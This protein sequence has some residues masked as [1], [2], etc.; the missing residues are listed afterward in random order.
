MAVGPLQIST[1]AIVVAMVVTLVAAVVGHS[2]V[3]LWQSTRTY[4]DA[5][6]AIAAN[7]TIDH[8]LRGGQ[9][10]AFERGRTN[11]VLSLPDPVNAPNRT[12]ITARRTAAETNLGEAL[13]QTAGLPHPALARLRDS[14][15]RLAEL[16]WRVDMALA[17]SLNDR[18][19]EL[20]REWF[21]AASDVLDD[22]GQSMAE[23]SLEPNRFSSQF[24]TY[25]RMKMLAYELR[26]ALGTESSR[27]AAATSETGP[28][29]VAALG[30]IMRLRGESLTTWRA[31][32]RETTL[33]QDPDLLAAVARVDERFFTALR[34]LQDHILDARL[35]GRP[36]PMDV[37]G[38]T[39]RSVPALDSVAELMETAAA[40]TEVTVA[41]HRDRTLHLMLLALARAAVATGFGAAVIYMI[42]ARLMVPLG[43]IQQHLRAL[44]TGDTAIQLPSARRRDEI[45]Q[46]QEAVA[47]FRDSLIERQRI[48]DDLE[49]QREQLTTLINAIPDVVCLKD[50]EG[51]WL[52]V[53][54][55][56]RR[57]FGLENVDC[58][59]R[60]NADLA[61]YSPSLG[62][63]GAGDWRAWE[64]RTSWRC[65]EVLTG[66]DGTPHI[67]DVVRVP[68]FG[69][70][71]GRKGLVVVGRDTTERRRIES[72]LARLSRQNE[73]LLEA[74]GDGIVGV[75]ADGD[76]VFA[77]PAAARLTGWDLHELLG[78]HHHQLIHHHHADGSPYPVAECPVSLTLRDGQPRRGTDETFWR[79]DGTPIVVEFSTDPMIE[80]GKVRGA[81]IVFRDTSER[82]R[83]QEAI[84]SLLAD[85]QRS[86][87]DLEQFAYAVSHDLQEPL[88]MVVSYLQMLKRRYDGRLDQDADEFIEFAVDGAKRMSGLINA[89]LEYARVGTRGKPPEPVELAVP[90]EQARHN[91]AVAIAESGAVLS[92][93][94][95][96]PQ[97]MG[98]EAQLGSLFQNL[99]GNAIK[100]R[101][102]DT[103]PAI[104]VA[105]RP[106]LAGWWVVTVGDNG[107]GIAA[108]DRDRA[109]GVFQ[110]LGARPDATGT[111][112][113]L[114]ICKRIVERLGGRIWIEDGT[115]GLGTHVVF[116]LRA[117]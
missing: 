47:A 11:V 89:L 74:A 22:I 28:L 21:A 113:G 76:T 45:G 91:L 39:G 52:V 43:R 77:N 19:P 26:N 90:L 55:N 81:V 79:K 87:T 72:A 44:A 37:A 105:V 10:L 46:M 67:Y 33:I 83:T 50:G 25:S 1:R 116:T 112:M 103:A 64:H 84:D 35:A 29:P 75:D 73:L 4:L 17:Q 56:G 100:Y 41:A 99:I 104:T 5:E 94:T 34:P 2:A 60:T 117:P 9:N 101:R 14:H 54:D 61:H 92:L 96:L 31:I 86:N 36:S 66:A 40:R 85:L 111:G 68:L 108:A 38:Y 18:P 23:L 48:A 51:H 88:R 6:E 3:E 8:L 16:R 57:L 69:P 49:H 32:R 78:T 20:A 115:D 114:A 82:K 98:D 24:R 93:D 15:R 30:E 80:Q 106:G 65:E 12:F 42:S 102:P 27:I 53:N 58:L 62:T 70:D 71:G 107:I 109:F 97:V 59:G 63:H 7:R 13:I 110:R 95:P